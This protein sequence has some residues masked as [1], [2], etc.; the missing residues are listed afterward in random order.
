LSFSAGPGQGSLAGSAIDSGISGTFDG[1]RLSFSGQF[2]TATNAAFAAA[3]YQGNLSGN[4]SS[5]IMAIVSADGAIFVFGTDGSVSDVGSGTLATD[6]SFAVTTSAGNVFRGAIEPSAS[7]L[8]GTMTGAMAGNFTSGL[9]TGGAY[10]DGT[11][12]GLSTR[13]FVGTGANVMIAGFIVNG[14]ASKRIV[15]RGIGPSMAPGVSGTLPN[16]KLDLFSGSNVIASNDDWASNSSAL[17]AAGFAAPTSVL[18]SALVANLSPGVYTA[19]LSGVSNATG[20]GLVEIYDTDAVSMFPSQKVTA[21]STR[22]FVNTGDGSMIAGFIV[23][24]T[25]SKKVLIEAVGPSLSGVPGLLADPVLRIVRM[26]DNAMIRENDNWEVGNDSALVRDAAS[27]SGATPLAAGGKDAAIL[28][29]L[30]PGVYTA[31]ASGAGGST[32]VALINV[33]EVP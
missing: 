26:S 18:E 25:A 6:G 27:R 31:V 19:Q 12:R 17:S 4:N 1:T 13:G 7:L 28:I 20:I 14:S 30:A 33:Y 24:G 32:G 21:V 5:D 16:P 29:T 2:G 15:I 11:L 10:S 23:E 3:Y 8:T 22:G 9:T